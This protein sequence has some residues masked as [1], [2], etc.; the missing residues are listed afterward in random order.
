[1]LGTD[2]PQVVA[3]GHLGLHGPLVALTP[4]L[5]AAV[6]GAAAWMSPVGRWPLA[7]IGVV[8]AW[9]LLALALLPG[10]AGEAYQQPL[11]GGW[12]ALDRL[13]VASAL[14]AALIVGVMARRL[15]PWW[16]AGAVALGLTLPLVV[17]A[18]IPHG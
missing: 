2:L 1:M 15:S 18:W 11:A 13:A 4:A 8:A 16:W 12:L 3:P 9:L 5:L 10:G 17:L 6:A 7:L 14:V